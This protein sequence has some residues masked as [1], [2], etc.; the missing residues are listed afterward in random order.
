M[1]VPATY[2]D[3]PVSA[4]AVSRWVVCQ[5][6]AREHYAVARALRRAG[7]L[8]LLVTDAWVRPGPMLAR[9]SPGLAGRFHPELAAA[10]DAAPGFSASLVEAALRLRYRRGWR[11]IMARNRQFQRA[12]L[13]RL[14]R[15][16]GGGVTIFAYSYA[17]RDILAYARTRG[18]RT[19]L[20]QIDPGPYE[21][22]IVASLHRAS[23][24][25]ADWSP[26]PAEYWNDW[27]AECA[28]AD[29]IVVNSKWSRDALAREGVPADKLSVVPL[30][31]EPPLEAAHFHR[32]VPSR[33]TV[34]R[35]L[36]VLF[37]GQINLRKGVEPLFGAIRHLADAPIEFWF[38]GPAQV[39]IA[40]D[41]GR[42][43]RVRW[44]GP[45]PRYA[46]NRFYR[47]ADVMILPSYSDGFGLT[48]LE[49]Q[50]WHLPV[51]ASR[52][53]G[54]V[55][56]DDENGFVLPVI[57]GPAIAAALRRLA[58]EDGLLARLSAGSAL[59]GGAG[60]ESL[61]ERLEALDHT[62]RAKVARP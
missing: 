24:L 29:T 43:P 50:A 31:I 15:V 55:V 53:C 57:T 32:V 11:L 56:R 22:R 18:W 46:T 40:V 28:L 41:L 62:S 45:V 38:V 7:R 20:G 39:E 42:S 27:R 52:F 3:A 13:A 26:A 17:A 34:E 2:L 47:D 14:A 60:I 23:S 9:L 8:D 51:I 44:L 6:G 58:L 48:Q 10:V 30:A 25:K 61:A 37:L 54:E 16:A 12:A 21:E 36:R 49:A 35:P 59:S 4:A 1:S 19:V 5:I 33:F